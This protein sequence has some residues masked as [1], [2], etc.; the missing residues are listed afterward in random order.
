MIK[1]TDIPL[2]ILGMVSTFAGLGLA[3]FSYAPLIPEMVAQGWFSASDAAYLGAVNLAGYLLGAVT[4]HWLSVRFGS[5]FLIRLSLIGIFLSFVLL[6]QPG[7]FIWF[8]LWRFVAGMAG[9]YLMILAPSLVIAQ[10][11]AER[12]SSLG[13]LVFMGIGFGIMMSASIVPMLSNISLGVSWLVL[14]LV[15]ALACLM[16]FINLNRIKLP[17]NNPS[18][19]QASALKS[20]E[21]VATIP[22]LLKVSLI[23]V[24]VAYGLDAVAYVPHSLFW[25][26]FLASEGGLGVGRAA[27][28]WFLF[29]LGAC[30]GPW[31][32]AWTSQ[33]VGPHKALIAALL[34]KSLGII[35]ALLPL[36]WLSN[37]MSSFLVGA[38]VP[39]VVG[40]TSASI[41]ANFGLSR[42]QVL[43]GV[44][45]TVFA[46][47]QAA[48]GYLMSWWFSME[49]SYLKL[50]EVATLIMTLALLLATVSHF[51]STRKPS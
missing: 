5:P 22:V 38:M 32:A 2:L 49:A 11:D 20:A 28:Q 42:H 1:K 7:W 33:R 36:H 51:F 29:G 30:F 17:D 27:I 46:L 24:I 25:V 34:I 4:A 8:G 18:T 45:T 31:F 44:A 19:E 23:L 9:A 35:L 14:G 15:A 21:P 40:L 50:F 47:G 26:D 3:R 16:G 37:S 12:R 6:A 41:A 10:A 39:A 48:S 43:W 13:V